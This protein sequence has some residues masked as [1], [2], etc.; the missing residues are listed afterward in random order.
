MVIEQVI[1]EKCRECGGK[2]IRIEWN[3]VSDVLCCDN[4]NCLELR[5]P[6]GIILVP[7]R[8]PP[9]S[10]LLLSRVCKESKPERML[11][12]WKSQAKIDR[13]LTKE[14]KGDR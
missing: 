3:S 11:S 8:P 14:L 6:Q 10:T 2:L 1:P 9:E 4:S 13:K 12:V 5:R 7:K